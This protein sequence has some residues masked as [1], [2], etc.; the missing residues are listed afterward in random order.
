MFYY[1]DSF[2]SYRIQ[3]S[4]PPYR[5][6]PYALAKLLPSTQIQWLLAWASLHHYH[7]F[8][9]TPFF[10]ILKEEPYSLEMSSLLYPL[11]YFISWFLTP[12][13]NR[14]LDCAFFWA[15]GSECIQAL[16]WFSTCLLYHY[17]AQRQMHSTNIY[18]AFTVG[19]A[20]SSFLKTILV[21]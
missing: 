9:Q 3:S 13:D 4:S 18:W 7:W 8:L 21:F 10:S 5:G 12:V 20:L 19:Q 11:F 17:H 15:Y 6:N 2:P 14:V 1:I 16:P